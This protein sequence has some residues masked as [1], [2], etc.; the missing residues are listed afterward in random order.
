MTK[1]ADGSGPEAS[2]SRLEW[3]S[4]DRALTVLAASLFLRVFVLYPVVRAYPVLDTAL[5]LAFSL[6]VVSALFA[7]AGG[8]AIRRL[9]VFM[10]VVALVTLWLNRAAPSR[11]LLIWKELAELLFVALIVILILRQVFGGGRVT[12]HRIV[13]AAVVYVLVGSLFESAYV[14]IEILAPGSFAAS[15]GAAAAREDLVYF[16]F[17]T[18]TTLGYGDITPVAV[19]ARRLALLEALVGQ[20]YPAILIGRLVSLEIAH[21]QER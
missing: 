4:P 9:V 13:G 20:L 18:L 21:R 5:D 2:L 6:V 19:A 3:L 12:L 17:V 11:A 1:P 10:G 15:G 14:L 16:S 7:I 8:R